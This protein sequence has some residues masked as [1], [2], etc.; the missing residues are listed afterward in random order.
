[1]HKQ[2]EL[3]LMIMMGKYGREAAKPLM[4][5][6]LNNKTPVNIVLQAF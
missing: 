2:Q 6:W 3:I 5:M 1:M 4:G